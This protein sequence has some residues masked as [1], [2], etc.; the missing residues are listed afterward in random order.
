MDATSIEFSA[1]AP[2]DSIA[3]SRTIIGSVT[4]TGNGAASGTLYI[5]VEIPAGSFFTVPEVQ[6]DSAT[7]GH[8]VVTVP[9]PQVMGSGTFQSSFRVRACLNSSSCSGNSDIRGS[10]Q[11]INVRYTV[12]DV[13]DSDTVMPRAVPAGAAGTTIL[14]GHGLTNTTSVRFGA[15]PA[16]TVTYVSATELRVAFPALPAGS[17]PVSLNASATPFTGTLVAVAI[18]NYPVAWIPYPFTPPIFPQGLV[19]DAERRAFALSLGANDTLAI[20]R[21]EYVGGAWVPAG[22]VD[23][24]FASQIRLSHDGS[25][26]VAL[27]R[28]LYQPSYLLDLDPVTLATLRTTTVDSNAWSFVLSNDGNFVFGTKFPGSGYLPPIMFGATNRTPITVNR[29]QLDTPAAIASGDGSKVLVTGQYG[30]VGMYDSSA[31]TWTSVQSTPLFGGWN[32][33]D[34]GSANLNGTRFASQGTVVDQNLQRIGWAGVQTTAEVMS[35]D[36]ARLYVYD[37]GDLNHGPQPVGLLRTFSA[38]VTMPGTDSQLVEIGT[39]IALANNPNGFYTSGDS[40]QMVVT[41]DGQTVII[42]GIVGCAL[43]PTPPP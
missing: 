26:L 1:T 9:T 24:Q 31:Q 40:V 19:Y 23:N 27:K 18:P 15:T 22:R 33:F 21:Y 16:S 14:R 7:S 3:L 38:N 8:L 2:F 12:G 35:P 25:R 28:T 36:G 39:P 4:P 11:T 10:P 34:Q 30:N 20:L 42:C 13:V 32:Y 29:I 17:Y 43:Q 41:P 6:V 37:Q 5:Y